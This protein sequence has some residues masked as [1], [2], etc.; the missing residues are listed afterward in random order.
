MGDV[1][2]HILRTDRLASFKL[3]GRFHSVTRHVSPMSKAKRSKVKV[4]VN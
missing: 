3:G 1:M 2:T 4:I